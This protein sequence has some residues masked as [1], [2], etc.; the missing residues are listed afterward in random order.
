MAARISSYAARS[1]LP[2]RGSPLRQASAPHTPVP[3]PDL[4]PSRILRPGPPEAL[5]DP[6]P[7]RTL[8]CAVRAPLLLLLFL[9][10]IRIS[11]PPSAA[12]PPV[13]GVAPGS[14]MAVSEQPLVD[15]RVLPLALSTCYTCFLRRGCR[16]SFSDAEPSLQYT[17]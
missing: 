6:E 16:P 1:R 13:L 4:A 9:P 5:P 10:S 14:E 2:F 12:R 15:I 8:H 7:S 3:H 17:W 11:T